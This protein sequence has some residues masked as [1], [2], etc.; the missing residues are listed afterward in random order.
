[1]NYNF[2][3]YIKDNLIFD[4]DLKS[5]HNINYIKSFFN[6]AIWSFMVY[7]QWIINDSNIIELSEFLS[8]SFCYIDYIVKSWKMFVSKD[9]FERMNKLVKVDITLDESHIEIADTVEEMFK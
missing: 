6:Y 4:W 8:S 9:S 7:K 2:K 5:E 3:I 1:M